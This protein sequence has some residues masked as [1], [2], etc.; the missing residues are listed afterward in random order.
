MWLL[1][2]ACYRPTFT[3]TFFLAGITQTRHKTTYA[4]TPQEAWVVP[5][6]SS[7]LLA[8]QCDAYIVLVSK[9]ERL[10]SGQFQFI[11]G[12]NVAL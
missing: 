7:K 1:I 10:F 4:G 8:E 12:T 2:S 6:V 5:F 3:V 11:Q 9:V